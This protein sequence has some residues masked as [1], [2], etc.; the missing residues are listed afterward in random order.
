MIDSDLAEMY[1]VN[2]GRLNEQ[3]KRNIE[4]FPDDFMFQLTE[5]EWE[6]LISQTAISS[7]GGRRKRPFVFTEQAVAML[8]SVLRSK[9][10][11]NVNIAIMR[12]FVKLRQMIE[13]N[14]DLKNQ[15]E[16]I[17][18]KYDQQFK[19]VFKAIKSLIQKKKEPRKPIGYKLPNR[20]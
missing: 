18:A 16:A 9:Q 4:R 5:K 2:T 14:Q 13:N 8:S 10:A 19:I 7:W 6:I 20:E 15:I 12:S 1:Q 17:E 3:V 11:I